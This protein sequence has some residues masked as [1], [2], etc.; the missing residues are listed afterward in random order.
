MRLKIPLTGTVV[1]DADGT[2]G[3]DP[4]DPV[5]IIELDL[6]NVAWK[7]VNFDLDKALVEIEVM[8][9]NFVSELDLDVRGKPKIDV[10]GKRLHKTRMATEQEK[11]SFL[12]YAKAMLEGHTPEELYQISNCPRLKQ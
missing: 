2:W 4:N 1:K 7:A 8:P 10:E 5:R 6:G 9:G 11:A 12:Q 3:G